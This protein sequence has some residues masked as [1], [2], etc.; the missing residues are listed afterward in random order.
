[1]AFRIALLVLTFLCWSLLLWMGSHTS[2][3]PTVFGRYSAAYTIFLL[4]FVALAVAA[5]ACHLPRIYARLFA[6]RAG[7][8]AVAVSLLIGWVAAELVLRIADPLGISYFEESRRYHLDKVADPTLVYRHAAGMDAVYQQVRV[9][10]NDMGLRDSRIDA[11]VPDELRVL[12]LGDSVAFGWGVAQDATFPAQLQKR[13]AKSLD[14]PVRVINSGVGSYNTVQQAAF[15][16]AYLDT[17]KPD[18]LLLLYVSN[19]IEIN[20]PPFDPWSDVSLRGKNPFTQLKLAAWHSWLY[21]LVQFINR[22]NQQP[23]DGPPDRSFKGWQQS[24]QAMESLAM[25]SQQRAIPLSVVMYRLGDSQF[26]AGLYQDIQ[27]RAQALGFA[28]ADALEWLKNVDPRAIT[29]SVVDAKH[30][31]AEGHRLLA[32]GLSE[33]ITRQ[34]ERLPVGNDNRSQAASR[35]SP[36]G[37][38]TPSS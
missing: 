27:E 12:V 19:D 14:R 25:L 7:I 6:G 2:D 8:T 23:G 18:M 29:N 35:L 15:A 5:T 28:H 36:P 9:T 17:L 4:P 26:T 38:A 10:T 21:R 37:A 31:N 16:R 32:E 20:D 30:P 22:I 11:K 24:M 34:L 3:E 13:L 33:L 1:M